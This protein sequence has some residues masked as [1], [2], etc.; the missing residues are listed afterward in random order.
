MTTAESI[1][2]LI[3]LAEKLIF[4]V[5]GKVIELNVKDLTKEDMLKALEQSKSANWP[6][7]EFKSSRKV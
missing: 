6:D 2:M 1:I 5:A 4:E 3:P 7:L